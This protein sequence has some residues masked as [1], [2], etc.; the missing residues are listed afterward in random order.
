MCMLGKQHT[1]HEH[2]RLEHEH[3][4]TT[5]QDVK[6]NHAKLRSLRTTQE[7]AGGPYNA[8]QECVKHEHVK[9]KHAQREHAK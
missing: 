8:R 1:A 6:Q 7:H 9:Q 2:A 4:H 5:L 3:E